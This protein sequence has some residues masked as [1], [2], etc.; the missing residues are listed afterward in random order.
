MIVT[1]TFSSYISLPKDCNK[2]YKMLILFLVIILGF[3]SL[4]LDFTRGSRG[5][6]SIYLITLLIGYLITFK[7]KNIQ[8]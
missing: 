4:L 8:N 2:K 1:L 5:N 7:Y 3:S 6:I